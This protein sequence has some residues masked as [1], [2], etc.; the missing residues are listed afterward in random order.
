MSFNIDNYETIGEQ[1]LEEIESKGLVLR[2]KKS[3]A[4]VVILSNQDDNKVFSIGFRT[5]PSDSTG[6]P[7]IIEHTVLCGSKEFPAKDPFIELTKG[8]LNTFLNA[9][10]YSD[11]TI[12]PIASCNNKDFANLMHVYMDAVFFPNIYKKEEIFKQEGWHYEL[13]EMDGE[14]I[15]NGVVYN[16]MKGAFSS[17]EEILFRSIQQA[18]LPDTPYG[19]ESGG[20]PDFIPDLSYEEFL[21]FHRKFYHASNSYIYLY[22]DMDIEERLKWMDLHYLSKFDKVEVDSSIKMQEPFGKM[23]ET[24]EEYSIGEEESEKEKTYLSYNVLIETSLDEKLYLAFQILE[25]ALLSAPGAPLK[26]AILDAGIGKDV[27]SSYD[28]GIQ[29][30][31]FSIITK[32]AEPWQKES[33][34]ALIKETLENIVKKGMDERALEGAI[35][36]FEFR[37]RE[38]D[39]GQYPKGLMYGIQILDSWLYHDEKPFIH[40]CADKTFAFLKE[41]I[42]TGYY[43]KLIQTYLIHSNHCAVVVVKPACGLT[44]RM[45][46]RL[47]EKL[48]NYKNSLTKE[49]KQ[50]LIQDTKALHGYEM[51]PATKEENETIPL[52]SRE[53]IDKK[54]KPLYNEEKEIAGVKVIHHRMHTNK[55]AY[56]R[57]SFDVTEYAEAASYLGLLS[58]M[59]GY[60]DT[61]N[62][63]FLEFSNEVNIHTGGLASDINVY[64]E[65]GFDGNYKAFFEIRTKVLYEKAAKALSIIEEMLSNTILEDEKRLKEILLETRS[66]MEMKMISKGHTTAVDRAMSYFC[67]SAVFEEMAGGIA[68]YE[69]IVDMEEHFE[70]KKSELISNLKKWMLSIFRKDNLIISYTADEQ[71]YEI[72]EENLPNFL[73]TLNG[74]EDKKIG[75]KNLKTEKTKEGFKTPGQVQYVARCGSYKA[76]GK[77]YT[78][79]LRVL[80]VI[81]SYDYLWNHIRVKGGAY[82]CMCGFSMSGYGYFT[83][84]RDPNLRE[85]DMVYG[86]LYE[87]VKNFT[88]EDRDMTKYVIGAISSLDVPMNPSAKGSRSFGAYLCGVTEE[89]LQKERDQVLA[90]D[91]ETIRNTAEIVKAIIEDDNLCVVGSETKIEENRD[92]FYV[93]RNLLA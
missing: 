83:S 64:N 60:V 2:H 22:G 81:L 57:M 69:F 5:P 16:E 92:M 40:L 17:P 35:N 82:G 75:R 91:R 27:L 10:T 93:V 54:C 62:Y 71:G 52:L 19:V 55:I 25:Y 72:L 61:K 41:S 67:E 87:Y 9:M 33:F 88:L 36:Y 53:D 76:S 13:E 63:S 8:S 14:L 4:R 21:A 59:L 74:R 66:R 1:N 84:Y 39:Y 15:Y 90:A 79:A 56:L 45:E 6:V 47:K 42:G 32:N 26:Q 80:K 46:E 34:V 23:Q 49:E 37:Y 38:A 85:T 51:T 73:S 89:D 77:E 65:K 58:T 31:I 30:P 12:Y 68:Y 48:E 86:G 28:N 50:Q 70:E 20:N 29:Q 44:N 3:G 78:G 7:H 43:E 11:K 24:V 18:V